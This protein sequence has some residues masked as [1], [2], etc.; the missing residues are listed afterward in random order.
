MWLLKK[1][2]EEESNDNPETGYHESV[3]SIENPPEE[4][5]T[6]PS[7]SEESLTTEDEEQILK[8]ESIG[9]VS[10]EDHFSLRSPSSTVH[11][12][13]AKIM[14]YEQG[15]SQILLEERTE[16]SKHTVT[17]KRMRGGTFSLR[18]L[19]AMYTLVALMLA[20]FLFVF[21][22]Q[23]VVFVLMEIPASGFAQQGT[24]VSVAR[25]FAALLSLPLFVYSMASIM[26]LATAFCGDTWNGGGL[27][28]STLD[29]SVVTVE[30]LCFAVYLGIPLFTIMLTLFLGLESWWGTSA[31][32]WIIS[33]FALFLL[34][35]LMVLY[36]ELK[37]CLDLVK[38]EQPESS[39]PVVLR[40]AILMT[41]MQRFAGTR[42]EKYVARCD[43]DND[44][45]EDKE[46]VQTNL[47]LLTMPTLWSCNICYDKIEP[48][49]R[50]SVEEQRDVTVFVTNN[51]WC[52]F[53]CC[54]LIIG[55]LLSSLQ[56]S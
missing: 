17:V 55:S 48:Q 34:F 6:V 52:V 37:T 5:S 53:A 9:Q 50:Y 36:H 44:L 46:P 43:G 32:V 38:L 29:W 23:V 10:F 7:P 30:W 45:I 15:N 31:A 1:A 2:T 19:R 20:A 39:W 16:G 26:A 33:V 40:N 3:G 18:V 22:F 27:L 28:R 49:R 42:R 41:Q 25:L 11:Y 12:R 14:V 8:E 51:S 54:L 24:E 4:S 56:G 21:S 13:G 35:C 47:G